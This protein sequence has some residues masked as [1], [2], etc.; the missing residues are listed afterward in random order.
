MVECRHGEL[1]PRCPF[2]GVPVQV[3]LRAPP[4]VSAQAATSSASAQSSP[5]R[6]NGLITTVPVPGDR[7][8]RLCPC[9][10]YDHCDAE[11]RQEARSACAGPRPSSTAWDGRAARSALRFAE[12]GAEP[13]EGTGSPEQR[14]RGPGLAGIRQPGRRAVGVASA[15]NLL[16]FCRTA[17]AVRASTT[18][19]WW[20]SPRESRG[21]GTSVSRTSRF[22]NSAGPSRGLSRSRPRADGSDTMRRH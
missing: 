4:H 11:A 20:R 13:V 5:S 6:R 15:G 8:G 22:R 3:R 18:A 2:E 12:G 19:T 14:L 21:S 7:T 17:N 9:L 16:L 1:K 10:L